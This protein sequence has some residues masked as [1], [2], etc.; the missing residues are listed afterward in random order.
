MLGRFSIQS[1]RV[2]SNGFRKSIAEGIVQDD[3]S[4]VV[5]KLEGWRKGVIRKYY[6]SIEQLLM[7]LSDVAYVYWL[8]FEEY[9]HVDPSVGHDTI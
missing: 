3:N 8:D 6:D 2:Y 1:K 7:S 5:D 4:V 9:T